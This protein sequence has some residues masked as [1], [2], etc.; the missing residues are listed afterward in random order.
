MSAPAKL[1]VP[2]SAS[3]LSP[4]GASATGTSAGPALTGAFFAMRQ[5]DDGAG[6]AL[7]PLYDAAAGAAASAAA[8][9][10]AFLVPLVALLGALAAISLVR[11]SGDRVATDPVLGAEPM[12]AER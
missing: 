5:G 6:D 12:R 2:A 11:R 4:A 7:N 1:T 9:S 8:Y 10:D 3:A